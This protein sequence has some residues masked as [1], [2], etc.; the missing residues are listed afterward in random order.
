MMLTCRSITDE[1]DWNTALLSLPHPH[2]LQTWEWGEVKRRHGWTPTRLLWESA[3]R[4]VA[5]AQVLRRPLPY[6]PWGLLYVPKGPLLDDGN[7]EI[8]EPVLDGLERSARHQKGVLIKIDPDTNSAAVVSRLAQRGWR[9]SAQQ[10]QFRNTALLALDAR[11]EELLGRMKSKTRYNIRLAERKGVRVRTG[12]VADIDLFYSM[13]AETAQRDG[14][15]IRPL[16]YYND[17]WRI[18]MDKNMAHMLLAEVEDKVVAGLIMFCFGTTAWYMY[19]AS[20]DVHRNLMPTYLLQWEAIRLA[21]ARGCTRYDLWGAPDRL[22]PS[23]RLWGVWRFKEGL[24]AQFTPHIGAY[25][26]APSRV[27]YWAYTVIMLKTLK[28]LKTFRVLGRLDRPAQKS[29]TG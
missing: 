24:G 10:I 27:L 1:G 16:T 5:A 2:V 19:G 11:E 9:Y 23:D 22:D 29:E 20:R 28:V 21:Q 6:T 17:A 18:F 8:W 14:F 4:P 13:Y 3:D 25:D 7:L 12:T 15:L 26:Y